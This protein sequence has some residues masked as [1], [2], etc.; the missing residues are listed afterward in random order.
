MICFITSRPDYILH[1]ET[2]DQDLATLLT[3]VKLDQHTHLFPHTH[4]QRGGQSGQLRSQ[5][6]SQ[7]SQDE[8]DQLVDMYSLDFELYG[9]DKYR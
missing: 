8:L 5:F 7:L 9:Y 2:L 6:V 1:L 3:S 4:T